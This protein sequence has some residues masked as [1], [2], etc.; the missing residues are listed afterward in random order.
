[1]LNEVV[2]E[3][4]R[5]LREWL[6]PSHRPATYRIG[7]GFA[8]LAG[9]IAPQGS[10]AAVTVEGV[11]SEI[12]AMERSSSPEFGPL[13]V[14]LSL[15]LPALSARLR[16]FLIGSTTTIETAFALALMPAAAVHLYLLEP[17]T[18][19]AR[20]RTR[21]KLALI[22]RLVDGAL[23]VAFVIPVGAACLLASIPVVLLRT[24][25]ARLRSTRGENK[26][27]VSD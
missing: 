6:L 22:L 7:R 23:I 26:H 1:M 3:L 20:E 12:T 19:A 8:R 27:Q 25:V 9:H 24:L 4:G 21:T 18:V 14:G 13:A 16:W 15:L 10:V 2:D 11:L 5:R 17:A